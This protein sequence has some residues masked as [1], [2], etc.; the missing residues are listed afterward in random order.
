MPKKPDGKSSKPVIYEDTEHWNGNW[1]A[2]A[3]LLQRETDPR[4]QEAEQKRAEQI[5]LV[6][7]KE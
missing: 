5:K 2:H 1:F 3:R 7:V 6:E 4:R